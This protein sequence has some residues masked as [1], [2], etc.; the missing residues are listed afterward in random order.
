GG[1]SSK[2]AV[3]SGSRRYCATGSRA[4]A[5][6]DRRASKSISIPTAFCSRAPSRFGEQPPN[7]K[8]RP[9][10]PVR[11]YGRR[12]P[13]RLAHELVAR[14]VSTGMLEGSHGK[15]LGD[16]AVGA[17]RAHGGLAG[18]SV[19]C[20]GAQGYT[21]PELGNQGRVGAEFPGRTRDRQTLSYRP[22]GPPGAE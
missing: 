19:R 15:K 8:E 7:V 18:A 6:P 16:I 14:S 2:P 12:Y 11:M 21:R 20:R 13:S 1:F 17:D 10:Y 9:P 5:S 22:L 4:S 3:T